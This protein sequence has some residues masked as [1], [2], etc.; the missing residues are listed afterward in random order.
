[1]QYAERFSFCLE[2]EIGIVWAISQIVIS[3]IWDFYFDGFTCP[4]PIFLSSKSV[5]SFRVYDISVFEFVRWFLFLFFPFLVGYHNFTMSTR[6]QV[7]VKCLNYS[8]I[9]F[10]QLK[11]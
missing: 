5:Y 6:Y 4:G 9:F 8:S 11:S 2:M 3:G 7:N 10:C 1:M